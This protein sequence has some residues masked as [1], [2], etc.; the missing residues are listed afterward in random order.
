MSLCIAQC[1]MMSSNGN[2]FRDT[3]P[4]CGNSPVTGEF[5]S[6]RP[7]TRSFDVFVSCAWTNRR[8]NNRD[9]RDLRRHRAHYDVTV[10]GFDACK[11]KE[12]VTKIFNPRGHWCGILFLRQ[13]F[14]NFNHYPFSIDRSVMINALRSRQNDRQFAGDILKYILQNVNVWISKISLK[15]VPKGVIDNIQALVKIMA[16]W[17]PGDKPLFEPMTVR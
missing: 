11:I 4:L 15:F 10:M 16:W 9:A 8:V 3:G 5:P 1:M 13:S 7:V 12:L 17:R 2:I 14:A 6:Q